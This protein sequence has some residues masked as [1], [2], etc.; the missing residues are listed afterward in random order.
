MRNDGCHRVGQQHY[1]MPDQEV[2]PS[3]SLAARPRVS[4]DP[5]SYLY[6]SFCWLLLPAPCTPQLL[7]GP[8]VVLSTRGQNPVLVSLP[9]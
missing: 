1:L 6:S 7:I 4:A 2:A 9:F 3:D 5:N 8:A